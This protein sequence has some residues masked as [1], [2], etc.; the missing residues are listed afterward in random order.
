MESA[1]DWC[2]YTEKETRKSLYTANES[3]AAEKWQRWD[4]ELVEEFDLWMIR[5]GKVLL[6]VL[7]GGLVLMFFS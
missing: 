2:F 5:F 6:T 3:T 7:V 1:N 4:E